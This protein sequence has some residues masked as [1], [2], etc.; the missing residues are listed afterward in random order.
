MA[1]KKVLI[2]PGHGGTDPGAVNGT[3][4]EKDKVLKLALELEKVLKEQGVE[5]VLTRR[6]DENL[7]LLQ[8]TSMENSMPFDCCISL[9]MDAA[10][11]SASG[12]TAWLHSAA[13]ASYAAWAQNTLALLKEVGYTSNRAQEVHKG[14]RGNANLNYAF[15]R[16]TYSPSMLLELGFI[17]NADNLREFDERYA[18][19]AEAVAKGICAFI[20]VKWQESQEGESQEGGSTDWRSQAEHYRQ[21]YTELQTEYRRL[22]EAHEAMVSSITALIEKYSA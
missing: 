10:G 13:P 18:Q 15:N 19:Y 2:D 20:G 8:R 14:Y 17:T 22:Q 9:H 5:C 11:A 7:T 1:T 16:D 3:Q 4:Y 12:M 21:A 6:S